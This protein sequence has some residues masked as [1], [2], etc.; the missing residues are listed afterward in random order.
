MVIR[1]KPSFSIVNQ[2][3]DK[4]HA[5]SKSLDSGFEWR[6]EHHLPTLRAE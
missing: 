3:L 5:C 2:G 4:S 6:F 1:Y